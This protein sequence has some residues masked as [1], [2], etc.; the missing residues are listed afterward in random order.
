MHPQLNR[1]FF[2]TP[3]GIAI[4]AITGAVLLWSL[5]V[6]LRP[7]PDRD[8]AI[9]TG[10]P[11]SA[12]VQV[13]ERYREI[14]A[15]HGV[16]LRLVPTNGAVENVDRLRDASAGIGV[17]FVQAGTTSE[18]QSPEL[19]SL[20]TVFYEPLWVFCACRDF[21]ELMRDHP[22]A[23]VSIGPEGSATRPLALQLLTLIGADTKRLQ[24]QSYRPDEAA[25][26][27][28]DGQIDVAIL[29]AAWES[30]NVQQL[31]VAPVELIGFRR[32]DAYVARD[33]HLSK[34]VLPEG[35]ADLKAN[36]PPA[37]VPLIAAKASLVVRKDLHP[38]LQYLLLHTAIEVHEK[39][40]IFQQ[41]GQFSRAGNH[42]SAVER[43]SAPPVQVRPVDPATNPAVLARGAGAA[44][45][46]HHPADRGHPLSALVAAATTLSM[47]DAAA[48]LPILRRAAAARD[49]VGPVQRPGR[50]RAGDRQDRGSGAPRLRA[51]DAKVLQ[52]DDLE[53]APAHSSAAGECEGIGV[54]QRIASLIMLCTAF[55]PGSPAARC[56]RCGCR[57][58]RCRSASST[59]AC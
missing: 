58:S 40:G 33:P 2:R 48:R 31:L 59:P 9:A 10:P 54:R 29:L 15:Q 41:A 6:L 52:R 47:A 1:N 57:T 50:A 51:E 27:L 11:G 21:G 45:A 4:L 12:Y 46:A 8:L 26:R 49:R 39:P 3:L 34:L 30:P 25:R 42:R 13:A 28:I 43:R 37:D 14:L 24:L 35:V 16:R 20:G 56:S 22:E 19:L 53:S 55:I 38:A 32:A 5:F 36:R 23:R 7:L 17:G 18:Q 44:A